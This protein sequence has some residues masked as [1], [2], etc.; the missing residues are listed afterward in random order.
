VDEAY[1]FW[2]RNEPHIMWLKKNAPEVHER[3]KN[4]FVNHKNKLTKASKK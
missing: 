1:S 2:N 4:A 3:V